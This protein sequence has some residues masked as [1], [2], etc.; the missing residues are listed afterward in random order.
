M[1]R[2]KPALP[3]LVTALLLTACLIMPLLFVSPSEPEP[4]GEA[5]TLGSA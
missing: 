1:S 4:D 2:L 3:W 5:L